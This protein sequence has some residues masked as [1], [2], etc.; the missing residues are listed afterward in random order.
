[1]RT[2]R[3]LEAIDAAV[4]DHKS[5][6][7]SSNPVHEAYPWALHSLDALGSI[8]HA[9]SAF[10]CTFSRHAFKTG[11]LLYLLAGSPFDQRERVRVRQGLLEYLALLDSLS[12]IEEAMR[13]LVVLFEPESPRLSVDTYHMQAWMVMQDWIDN[14]PLPWPSTIPR[15]PHSPYWSLCFRGV[16]LFVNVST[17]AHSTRRSRNLGPS[18][19]LVTQP[20]AGFDR[21]AGDT[22]EGDKVRAH[23]R[24]LM[25]DY[26]EVPAPGEL[27]TYGRGDLEWCQY[28]LLEHNTPRADRCPLSVQDTSETPR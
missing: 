13:A 4:L 9:P 18:L 6:F 27:G 12:G 25:A 23:I 5:A 7:N 2:T 15:D 22:P 17:P 16:P 26:D 24:R 3:A 11:K 1:M 19:A 20:R 8:L 14:D 28:T 21:V 10:P